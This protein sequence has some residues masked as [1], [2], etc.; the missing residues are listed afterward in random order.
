MSAARKNFRI[1]ERGWPLYAAITW[2]SLVAICAI[3][4]QSGYCFSLGPREGLSFAR[5]PQSAAS[6]GSARASH[7]AG[8]DSGG[9]QLR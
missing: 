4:A 5:C 2:I 6:G 3:A 1:V 8:S 7:P 9:A